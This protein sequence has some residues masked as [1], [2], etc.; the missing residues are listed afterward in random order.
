MTHIIIHNRV[1]ILQTYLLDL[2]SKLLSRDIKLMDLDRIPDIHILRKTGSSIGIDEVKDLQKDM[3]YK[4]FEL[5]YQI[6]VIM[7][8]HLLTDE[9]QNAFL[10]TLEESSDS[11]IYILLLNNEKN[12]LPTILSRGTKHYIKAQKEQ[13]LDSIRPEILETELV[14]QFQIIENLAKEKNDDLVNM[15]V[16]I[17]KYFREQLRIDIQNGGDVQNSLKKVEIVNTALARLKANGNKRLVVENLFIQ[18]ST[19]SN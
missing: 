9:A 4:P 16:E 13:T 7:D 14:D 12:L 5:E 10:K 19:N 15:L 3:I 17:S 18:L 11:S 6:A 1:E 2:L 8:S